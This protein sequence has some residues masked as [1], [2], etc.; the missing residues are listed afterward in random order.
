MSRP[1]FFYIIVIDIKMK[2][3]DIEKIGT[4]LVIAHEKAQGREI[5]RPKFKGCGWDLCTGNPNETRYIEIKTTRSK[6][7]TGR[8]LEKAGYNQFR[9][10]PDFYI[11][12]VTEVKEDGTGIITVYKPSDIT[13]EED[14][15]Y[16]LKF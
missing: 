10:N 14:I 15:K 1:L 12:G 11:Y 8:W 4:D 16:V 6:K 3:L 2:N 5:F 7:L 13:I 9:M